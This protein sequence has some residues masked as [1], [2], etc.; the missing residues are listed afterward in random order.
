MAAMKYESDN[1]PRTK[2]GV[3]VERF[4]NAFNK[5]KEGYQLNSFGIKGILD[6]EFLDEDFVPSIREEPLY[7]A[8]EDFY[9]KLT[10]EDNQSG[11]IFSLEKLRKKHAPCQTAYL[12]DRLKQQ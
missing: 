1:T 6:R 2:F 10:K 3:T 9:S 7:F 5:I 12:I 11:I 8:V 4:D